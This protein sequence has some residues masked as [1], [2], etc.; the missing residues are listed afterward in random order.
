MGAAVQ[1]DLYLAVT[2]P[3]KQQRSAGDGAGN[4]IAGLGDFSLVAYI[5][6][7]FVVNLR[8]LLL[9]KFCISKGPF[10]DQVEVVVRLV[11][12]ELVT[13]GFHLENSQLDELKWVKR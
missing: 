4:K 12:D 8:D 11:E 6:P 13:I 3:H 9:K 10:I 1:I 2:A 5:E 7:E